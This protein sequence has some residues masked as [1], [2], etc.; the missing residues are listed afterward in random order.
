MSPQSS[1]FD[2]DIVGSPSTP[3]I[4]STQPSDIRK[5][6]EDSPKVKSQISNGNQVS[7]VSERN[8]NLQEGLFKTVEELERHLLQQPK[9]LTME[10]LERNLLS[11]RSLPSNSIRSVEEIE[12]ELTRTPNSKPIGM[13]PPPPPHLQSFMRLPPPMGLSLPPPARAPM[14]HPMHIPMPLPLPG[15]RPNGQM[16]LLSQPTQWARRPPQS[17]NQTSYSTND[18]SKGH[19]HDQ[20]HTTAAENYDDYAGL[21]STKEKQWLMSIQINQLISDNPYVEDYYFTVLRLRCLGK[22][23]PG[24]DGKEGPKLIMPGKAKTEPRTYAPTQFANSLGKLQ[25]VTYTAPRRILDVSISQSSP[26]TG[27]DPQMAVK[28]MRKFKQILLDIEKMY[29]W[30]L[31]LEDAEMRVE[32]LPI[33]AEP[34]P[35][36]QVAAD[37][38]IKLQSFLATGDRL[39][40][41]MLVRKGKVSQK[42]R[43][44]YLNVQI[45]IRSCF[46]S[47]QVL[48]LRAWSRFTQPFQELIARTILLNCLILIRR[49]VHDHVLVRFL[50]LVNDILASLEDLQGLVS[51]SQLIDAAQKNSGYGSVTSTKVRTI[52]QNF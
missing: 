16:P 9:R 1:I 33:D 29:V 12:A 18:S 48:I 52:I 23:H 7:H 32:S 36:H 19:V 46:I 20:R 43:S 21:M 3:S 42:E 49:D 2:T 5:S 44:V 26:E 11:N 51:M 22:L 34:G 17:T 47:I 41:V 13:M 40:Q 14:P 35:H 30:L 4:W 27:Q 8:L 38:Q 6:T 10:E 39:Q 28:D 37:Y 24:R 25:V 15:T 31:D 45:S 50:P